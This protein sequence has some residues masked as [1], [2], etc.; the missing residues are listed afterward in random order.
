MFSGF[1]FGV[2]LPRKGYGTETG[3]KPACPTDLLGGLLPIS[4]FSADWEKVTLAIPTLMRSTMV[5]PVNHCCSGEGR[6][7]E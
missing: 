2:S 7:D 5:V 6:A 3:Q 1:I 4:P